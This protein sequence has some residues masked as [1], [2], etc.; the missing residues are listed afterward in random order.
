[1]S[2]KAS[3]RFQKFMEHF[4]VVI[5]TLQKIEQGTLPD[6]FSTTCVHEQESSD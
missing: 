2:G 3:E 1:M 5:F 4:I 6:V